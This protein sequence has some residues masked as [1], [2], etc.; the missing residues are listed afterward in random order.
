MENAKYIFRELDDK[1]MVLIFDNEEDEYYNCCLI[2][3]TKDMDTFRILKN[4]FTDYANELISNN[5]EEI[6]YLR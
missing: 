1:L 3:P 6:R 4:D 5:F 2:N